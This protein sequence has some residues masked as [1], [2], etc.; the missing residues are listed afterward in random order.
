MPRRVASGSGSR[1]A[2]D[3]AC[4]RADKTPE[5]SNTSPKITPIADVDTPAA[6]NA[7]NKAPSVV[8]ISRNIPMRMLEKASLRY[9]TAAP[10]EVAMTETSEAP[11]AYLISTLKANVSRGTRTTPPPRPVREPRNPAANDP[12]LTRIVNS[13]TFMPP[14]QPVCHRPSNLV[15]RPVRSG[16]V[17]NYKLLRCRVD[18]R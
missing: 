16:W 11:T 2:V 5:Y 10:D 17:V 4:S 8:A 1:V 18:A 14:P 13:R 9:D 15:R 7:P 6:R 12:K 3:S